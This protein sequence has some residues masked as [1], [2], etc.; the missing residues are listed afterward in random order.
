LDYKNNLLALSGKKSALIGGGID[1]Q[2]AFLNLYNIPLDDNFIKY[3]IIKH[4]I[5]QYPIAVR[6]FDSTDQQQKVVKYRIIEKAGSG[7][8]GTVYK[9]EQTEPQPPPPPPGSNNSFAIKLTILDVGDSIHNAEKER[10]K[11]AENK[12][13]GEEIDDLQVEGRV[14]AIYQGRTGN[15]DFAIYNYLGENLETFLKKGGITRKTLSSLIQQL[16]DQLYKLNHSNAFHN[17]VKKEN[18]VVRSTDAHGNL[19]LSLIDYGLYTH[20][21]SNMGSCY[22]MC[23]SGCAKSYLDIKFPKI[24]ENLKKLRDLIDNIKA[25]NT[26]YVGFFNVIICLLNPNFCAWSI[27]VDILKIG[28]ILNDIIILNVLCLLCYVSNSAKCEPLFEHPI[29]IEIVKKID[30]NLKTSINPIELFKD[31]VSAGYIRPPEQRRIL[32]LSYLYFKITSNP[33][34][35]YATF[36]HITKLPRLL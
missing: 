7:T 16:H 6:Y 32:F 20:D 21:T 18:I 31:F 35:R 9:L 27:Y 8:T 11:N 24:D 33:M 19:E 26:D 13:E 12:K 2:I 4:N 36:V 30:T 29:C 17:D 22:S 15:I 25:T 1:A 23:I 5:T 10:E 28:G 14:K 3:Y 34:H